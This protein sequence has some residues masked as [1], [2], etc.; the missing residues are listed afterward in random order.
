[1]LNRID[2]DAGGVAGVHF[3]EDLAPVAFY[4]AHALEDLVA[5]LLGGI[6]LADKADDLHSLCRRKAEE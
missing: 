2:H 1:M 4:G 6:F 3:V 5:D